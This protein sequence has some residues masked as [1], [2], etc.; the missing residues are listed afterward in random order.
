MPRY[1]YSTPNWQPPARSAPSRRSGSLQH[2][3]IWLPMSVLR[4][5]GSHVPS[6]RLDQDH[7]TYTPGTTWPVN[8]SPPRCSQGLPLN[9]GF[10]A[11]SPDFDASAVVHSRSSSQPTPDPI[12]SDLLR[13]AHHP[14]S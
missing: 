9:P 2:R 10:D 7:A 5:T 14:G 4:A 3:R 11:N 13:I 8:R 6:E 1:R 12:T